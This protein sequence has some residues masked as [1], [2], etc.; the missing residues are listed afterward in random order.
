VRTGVSQGRRS[1]YAL[2]GITQ[3]H[4]AGLWGWRVHVRRGVAGATEG[5]RI[6]HD[7]TQVHA[8]GVCV[9]WR[10]C[11]YLLAC[12]G[13]CVCTLEPACAGGAMEIRSVATTTEWHERRAHMHGCEEGSM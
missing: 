4:D 1:G 9:C 7:H 3:V 2:C 11:V 6:M 8:H 13:P 12:I 5:V 10:T